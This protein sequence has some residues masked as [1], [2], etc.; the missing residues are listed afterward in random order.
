M[1]HTLYV[2]PQ[3]GWRKHIISIL[4]GSLTGMLYDC[5]LSTLEENFS[6][7]LALSCNKTPLNK[8]FP[9]LAN[10]APS[11]SLQNYSSFD[12]NANVH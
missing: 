4:V 11:F 8:I 7:T 2:E 12:C 6:K 5:K 3:E 1:L 10:V 9:Q